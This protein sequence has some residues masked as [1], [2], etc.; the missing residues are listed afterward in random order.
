[1]PPAEHTTLGYLQCAC[2][3]KR[4][5]LVTTHLLRPHKTHDR[6]ASNWVL[7]LESRQPLF[8]PWPPH[9]TPLAIGLICFDHG[10]EVLDKD[11]TSKGRHGIQYQFCQQHMAVMLKHDSW[12]SATSQQVKVRSI[13]FSQEPQAVETLKYTR[14]RH[15]IELVAVKIPAYHRVGDIHKVFRLCSRFE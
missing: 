12:L 7:L 2:G 9:P 1:M 5:Q 13:E 10:R 6:H 4:D 8:H 14:R 3:H 11:G 15:G